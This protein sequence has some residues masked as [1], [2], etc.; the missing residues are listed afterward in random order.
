MA[1]LVTDCP[2]CG[3]NKITFDLR[4]AVKIAYK[5]EWQYWYE[6]FC[7]CRQCKRSTVFI[8][9]ESVN[10]DY[11]VVHK[12][13]LTQIQGAVNRY[14][15]IKGFISLKDTV[16]VAPPNHV[17]DRVASIFREGAICSSVKCNNATGTMFR[18][19]IDLATQPLLPQE[20]VEGLNFKTR[21][22]LGLR[23]PWLIKHGYL[24]KELDELSR[25]VKED[26]NDGAHA[27]TLSAD[28]AAELLDFTRILLE[29][30]FT[31]PERLRI[32][33]ERR[34]ER[35]GKASS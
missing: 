28:D 22:D 16:K 10:G 7:C 27:G 13:G 34:N 8:L 33:E 6:A 12:T 31:E 2:R 18:L 35:R 29:R 5:Y 14:V 23:L 17:P 3:A 24:P 1:E 30:L 4:D 32:A 19:C 15:D 20:E 26:G 9:V 25:C 21:R 11:D